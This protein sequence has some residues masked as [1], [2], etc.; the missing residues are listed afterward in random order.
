M[1]E[2]QAMT[3]EGNAP[4]TRI[5]N[6]TLATGIPPGLRDVHALVAVTTPRRPAQEAT[7]CR[8]RL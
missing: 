6:W 1:D 4:D 8:D 2:E 7:S 5:S 3:N